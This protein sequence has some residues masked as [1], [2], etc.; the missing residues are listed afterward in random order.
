[1]HQQPEGLTP[2]RDAR[3][4]MNFAVILITTYAVSLEVFLRRGMGVR[5]LD[6]RAAAV[7]LLVPGHTCLMPQHHDRGLILFLAAYLIACF[8]QRIGMWRRRWR[9][10]PEPHSRYNG[11]P[12]LMGPSATI[13]EVTFKTWIEPPLVGLVAGVLLCGID[14]LLGTYLLFAAISLH[15]QSRLCSHVEEAQQTD[16]R[17][18]MIEQQ[19]RAARFRSQQAQVAH[20]LRNPFN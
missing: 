13:D 4:A 16:L 19:Q 17:D 9:R 18:A 2:I 11:F 3:A 12:R 7:L 10:L 8:W 15:L 14:E 6:W 20:I 5:H 1:M